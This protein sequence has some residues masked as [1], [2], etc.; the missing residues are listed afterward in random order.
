M[1]YYFPVQITGS[2]GGILKMK[3]YSTHHEWVKLDGDDAIIG[4]TEYAIKKL[5][6]D[7]TYVELPREGADFIVGDVI[8]VVESVRES[9]DV[10]SPVSGTVIATNRN[11]DDDPGIIADGEKGWICKLENTDLA[12]LDDLMEEK[13]YLKYIKKLG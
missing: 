12:E 8:S 2:L 7:L 9:M 11:L 1:L 13:A 6:G 3:Y 4:V 5:G 10:Q